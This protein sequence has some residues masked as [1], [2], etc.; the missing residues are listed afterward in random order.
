MVRP[1]VI[2]GVLDS[3]EHS[4]NR[5][6]R[7]PPMAALRPQIAWNHLRGETAAFSVLR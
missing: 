2:L 1:P 4:P 6:A 5:Q 3:L 7:A